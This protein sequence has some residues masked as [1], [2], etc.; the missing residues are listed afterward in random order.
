MKK[1]IFATMCCAVVTAASA[2]SFASCQGTEEGYNGYVVFKKGNAEGDALESYFTSGL[3]TGP[4][5]TVTNNNC[6]IIVC[7]ESGGGGVLVWPSTNLADDHSSL[8][9][10]GSTD[11]FIYVGET[12]TYNN[13][14]A[15]KWIPYCAT[16]TWGWDMVSDLESVS[17][18]SFTSCRGDYIVGYAVFCA[19]QLIGDIGMSCGEAIVLENKN[20]VTAMSEEYVRGK[21]AEVISSF[22]AIE[23]EYIAERNA[24]AKD[25]LYNGGI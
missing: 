10:G 23:E 12:V 24:Y 9:H 22:E 2:V 5:M 16:T 20:S 19:Y 15:V 14:A 7:N 3:I 13:V 18:I 11:K 4:D 21:I 8:P 1:R 25:K 17:Y 6:E